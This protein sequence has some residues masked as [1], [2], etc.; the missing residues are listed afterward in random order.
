MRTMR[1]H[2]LRVAHRI[3]QAAVIF[4]VTR[5]AFLNKFA[6]FLSMT[7]ALLSFLDTAARTAMTEPIQSNQDARQELA[8]ILSEFHTHRIPTTV[9][10]FTLRLFYA[11]YTTDDKSTEAAIGAFVGWMESLPPVDTLVVPSSTPATSPSQLQDWVNNLH[12]VSSTSSAGGIGTAPMAQYSYET[13][14]SPT[15]R[16]DQNVL[17]GARRI[18]VTTH[19]PGGGLDNMG[20]DASL[21][22]QQPGQ[23]NTSRIHESNREPSSN[24]KPALDGE[25]AP[26]LTDELAHAREQIKQ[27]TLNTSRGTTTSDQRVESTWFNCFPSRLPNPDGD[28]RE[29]NDRSCACTIQ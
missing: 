19:P 6:S 22:Q 29:D 24:D 28:E 18:A 12:S 25:N 23:D 17:L 11:Q 14:V 26:L 15:D 21:D 27:S 4:C 5:H 8:R 20:I 2:R 16:R 1:V 13:E 3:D 10:R 7:Q 9:V